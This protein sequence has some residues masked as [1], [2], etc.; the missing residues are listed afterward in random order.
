MKPYNDDFWI[1]SQTRK[2]WCLTRTVF[3]DPC[4]EEKEKKKAAFQSRQIAK[5]RSVELAYLKRAFI[6]TYMH[7]CVRLLIV[8]R[9]GICGNLARAI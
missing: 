1:M 9:A 7:V 8:M 3:A 5:H 2:F 6:L 4:R